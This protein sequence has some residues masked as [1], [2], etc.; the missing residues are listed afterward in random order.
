MMNRLLDYFY[1]GQNATSGPEKVW[2]ACYPVISKPGKGYGLLSRIGGSPVLI[3]LLLAIWGIPGAAQSQADTLPQV[4]S[5][6]TSADSVDS[7]RADST[8]SPFL[9]ESELTDSLYQDTLS[10]PQPERSP[11]LTSDTI[12]VFLLRRVEN[13]A[14]TLNELN[15]QLQQPLDTAVIHANL[16]LMDRELLMIRNYYEEFSKQRLDLR[17]LQSIQSILKEISARLTRLEEEILRY[18]QHLIQYQATIDQIERD[19]SNRL[20]PADPVLQRSYLN[21]LENL[22]DRYQRVRNQLKERLLEL[23]LM[24]EQLTRHSIDI[25]DLE[26]RTERQIHQY[27]RQFFNANHTALWELEKSDYPRDMWAIWAISIQTAGDTL[28]YFTRYNWGIRAVNIFLILFFYSFARFNLRKIKIDP[29][30]SEAAILTPLVYYKNYPAFSALATGLTIAPFLY[31]T[32]PL[33]FVET[34][35]VVLFGLITWLLYKRISKA[36][37]PYWLGLFL[38]FI[39]NGIIILMMMTSVFERWLL[40]GMDSVAVVLGLA[41]LRKEQFRQ[42]RPLNNLYVNRLLIGLFLGMNLLAIVFNV[43]G[44]YN[45]AMTMSYAGTFQIIYAIAL[46]VFIEMLGELG[47][48]YIEANKEGLKSYSSWLDYQDLQN[49]LKRVLGIF[50]VLMWLGI[51]SRSLGVFE[52]AYEAI[53]QFLTQARRIGS[54]SFT[55]G[56]LTIFILI[57][58]FSLLLSR[59]LAYL[60]GNH[61]VLIASDRKNNLG[62]T[63]LLVRIGVLTAG[64]LLALSAAGISLDKVAIVLGALGVGIGFGLQGLVN[65]L[66]SGIILAFE[67]PLKIGDVIEL[68]PFMGRVKEIG[69]R[70]SKVA[71][72]DGADVIIPNGD[73][74][75]QHLTNWTLSNQTRRI[76]V[77]VGVGY[78]SDIPSAREVIQG[79]IESQEMVMKFPAPN[80]LVHNFNDSSVD[81]RVLFWTS[82]FDEWVSVKSNVLGAI[83]DELYKA[84]IEIP[85]PKRDVFVHYPE[86]TDNGREILP[87]ND[88]KENAGEQAE[89]KDPG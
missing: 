21:Q 10:T 13:L 48:L 80:V 83:Y 2:P 60:F 9:S 50:A 53:T 65:N 8:S 18:S 66:V 29:E 34:I 31:G 41:V 64:F 76:E 32:P 54:F 39:L 16:R 37:F 85:F 4:D 58:Y 77:L 44:Y 81:F 12:A 35:W 67:K 42:W 82:R 75:S 86:K 79:A 52:V 88:R 15:Q 45:L 73:L 24:Q 61:E 59:L 68:G 71:T 33:V 51:F 43:F 49:R 25:N 87:E 17:S 22:S 69:I 63:M 14:K 89:D 20:L 36:V 84:G 7:L 30:K 74:L 27:R 46:W 5:F 40:L 56:S 1:E 3:L 28:A 38:L 23:G 62:S 19:S 72:F 57:I 70:S 26:L 11:V 6:A 47:F 78:G 55:Y